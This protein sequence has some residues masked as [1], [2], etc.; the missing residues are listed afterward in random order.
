MKNYH[1]DMKNGSVRTDI[2]QSKFTR[3]IYEMIDPMVGLA[4]YTLESTEY[5]ASGSEKFQ[6]WTFAKGA[7]FYNTLYSIDLDEYYRIIKEHGNSE[8]KFYPT[9]EECFSKY[10]KLP[11]VYLLIMQVLDIISFDS[12]LCL[13][14]TRR[15]DSN[16]TKEYTR[17]E[18]LSKKNTGIG[19]G[20]YS[21]TSYYYNDDF[22]VRLIG[23]G[24]YEGKECWIYDYYAEPS[25]VF[26]KDAKSGRTKNSKSIYSGRLY[27]KKEDGECIGGEMNENVVPI[28]TKSNFVNRRVVLEMEGL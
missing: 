18:E 24:L 1:V 12:Y 16:I 15:R 28:G 3:E 22:Y 10:P 6:T 21:D 19:A 27:V 7:E 2:L 20:Q 17:L 8:K 23:N 11:S 4:K 9:L 26:M 14:N 5:M 25:S 13:I